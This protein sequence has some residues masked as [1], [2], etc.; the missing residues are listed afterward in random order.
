MFRCSVFHVISILEALRSTILVMK[1]TVSKDHN[2]K[3][4]NSSILQKTKQTKSLVIIVLVCAVALFGASGYYWYHAVFTDPDRILSDT[5]N[6]SLQ[7][8]SVDRTITQESGQNKVNQSMYVEF[9]PKVLAQSVTNLEEETSLGKTT[10]T[11]ETIGTKDTDYVQYRSIEVANN[12]TANDRFNDVIN[13]WAK[14][15]SNPE[16]GQ[17][18]SFLNDALFAAVPFGNFN[19]GQR[20]ELKKEI[21][22]ANLYNTTDHKLSWQDGR[23]VMEYT[24]TLSPRALI[25][26]LAKYSQLSG[27]GESSDFDPSQYEGASN[28]TIKMNIDVLS[29]H[30]NSV[31]YLGSDRVE[32]YGAYNA[33]R[34]VDTPSKTISIDELQ[35]RV[36]GVEQ[37]TSGQ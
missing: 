27:V 29:R 7:T 28:I 3:I 16:Q 30:V 10:V 34:N 14:R 1:K 13:T 15:A 8:T 18:V 17:Q 4:S 26:V 22:K 32:S 36:G 23:P 2:L 19:H 21:K 31:D 24:M 5:L 35:T 9:T 33:V 12:P 25:Q 6:K 11:T 37:N 20:A